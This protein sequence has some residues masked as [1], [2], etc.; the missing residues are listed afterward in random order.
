MASLDVAFEGAD[1]IR[2]LWEDWYRL[3]EGFRVGPPDIRDFGNGVVMAVSRVGGR[4]VGSADLS[5]DLAMIYEWSNGKVVHVTGIRAESGRA[6]A[7][8]LANERG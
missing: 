1:A 7:E 5:Q 3:Y 8:R 2:G 6:A 4:L